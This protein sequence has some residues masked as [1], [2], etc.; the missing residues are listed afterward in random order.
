MDGFE[1]LRAEEE[2]LQAGEYRLAWIEHVD[3]KPTPEQVEMCLTDVNLYLRFLCARRMGWTPTP[4]QIERGLTDENRG[5]RY[6]WTKRMNWT[7]TPEQ[8]ERGLAD[9]D[10]LVQRM[11]IE[12]IKKMS[13]SLLEHPIDD[14]AQFIL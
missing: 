9:G 14:D 2:S 3:C 6:A 8:I 13:D 10:E 12:R 11:W 1:R 5:V 7:P 4:E